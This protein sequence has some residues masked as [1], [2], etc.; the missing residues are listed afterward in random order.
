[1]LPRIEPRCTDP[2]KGFRR[3]LTWQDFE[4]LVALQCSE[5][6]IL[7]YAGVKRSR[8]ASWCRKTYGKPLAEMMQ[9]IRQDGLVEI[10]RASFDQLKKSVTL[11]AQQFKRYLPSVGAG[12]RTEAEAAVREFCASLNVD[13]ETVRE[14]YACSD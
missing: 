6:E 5:E 2:L 1:M 10:R 9:M 13:D 4:D 11:I 8:L 14:I 7:G 12:D 3:E